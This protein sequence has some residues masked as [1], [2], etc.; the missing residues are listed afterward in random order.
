MITEAKIPRKMEGE[1]LERIINKYNKN[2]YVEKD[3]KAIKK[4]YELAEKEDLIIFG[5]SLYCNWGC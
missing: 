3:I 5:G 4:S 1:V 2:T